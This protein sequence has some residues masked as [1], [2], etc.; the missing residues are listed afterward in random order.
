MAE[1]FISGS[2]LLDYCLQARDKERTAS[3]EAGRCFGFISG[4]TDLH[5]ILI[6]EGIVK[7]SYCPPGNVSLIRMVNVVVEYLQQHPEDL[8]YSAS[9]LVMAAYADAFPCARP[10]PV[11]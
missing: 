6:S 3:H 5:D 9:S 7:P 10:H 8:H 11:K 1:G 2:Q 4:V